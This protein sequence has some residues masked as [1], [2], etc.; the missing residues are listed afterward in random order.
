MPAPRPCTS[1]RQTFVHKFS[2]DGSGAA[3]YTASGV[4]AGTP[5]NSYSFD[6]DDSGT[7]RF[8]ANGL[9]FDPANP[10]VSW[11]TYS[12]LGTMANV[13]GQLK[14][15]G[16]TEPIAVGERMQS[17]RFIGPRAYLVT[18]RQIDPLFVYDMTSNGGP[19]RLGELK[20]PG[21]STYL[22]PIDAN[23]LLGIGYDG[24][25]WPRKIKASLF[26]VTDPRN[27]REQSTLTIG[28]FYSASDALWDPH[29]FNYLARDASGGT[30]AIPLWSY[31]YAPYFSQHS[32]LALVNVSTVTGLAAAGALS[33]A[34]RLNNSPSNYNDNS[35]HFVRRSILADGYA[36]AVGNKLVRSATIAQPD[37]PVATL[38]LP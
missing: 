14:V 8:A 11:Q 27:P 22:H 6:E 32:S 1:A 4:Y 24:G 23:H 12:Y 17:V 33:V 3:N 35:D 10:N 29:A 38:L 5:L 28:E 18:F 31:S 21:F 20:V 16:K 7:L 36:F 2:I 26:D 37:K 9:K 25:A 19:T 30:L 15:T 34:D 13:G